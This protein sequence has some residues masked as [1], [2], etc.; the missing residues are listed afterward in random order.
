MSGSAVMNVRC[1]IMN[2]GCQ[3]L[4]ICFTIPMVY[5]MNTPLF[6]VNSNLQ[7][8]LL[9]PVWKMSIITQFCLL[10]QSIRDW[11]TYT[12]QTFGLGF[13]KPRNP[14]HGTASMRIFI[15]C[16]K[17]S[18]ESTSIGRQREKWSNLLFLT[19]PSSA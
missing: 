3:R 2:V 12:K 1:K 14:R 6:C 8:Y 13:W 4:F 19:V 9:F 18:K 10:W 7:H 11:I 17:M 15:Q 16:H 5:L